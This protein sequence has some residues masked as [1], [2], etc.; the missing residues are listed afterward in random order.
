MVPAFRS[1]G[2]ATGLK[3]ELSLNQLYDKLLDQ[4]GPQGWWP[5]DN[6]IEIILGA[7]LVQ[8]TAWANVAKSLTNLKP[9]TDFQGSK[10]A[11]LTQNEVIELIR[12]SGF[13]Q[14]KSRAIVEFFAWLKPFQ[15]DFEQIK[16]KFGPALRDQLLTFHGIGDETADV[17]LLYVFDTP[18]FVADN[19]AQ[20]LF[21]ALGVPSQNYRNLRQLVQ[22]FT[23]S[24]A[25]AQEFHGLI[26]EFGKLYFK[27][28]TFAESFLADD[29]LTL[30]LKS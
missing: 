9:V 3:V 30:E 1:S 21:Q 16:Q 12:P 11:Q 4:M 29:Q 24:L 15:F 5:A 18:V 2:M 28:K 22:P 25:Q 26:D 20:K 14:N 10:V 6:K 17:L 8:N 13:Y 27:E 7:I 19:Y 23:F